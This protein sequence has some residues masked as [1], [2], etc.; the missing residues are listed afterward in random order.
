MPGSRLVTFF[1]L[2][3]QNQQLTVDSRFIYSLCSPLLQHLTANVDAARRVTRQVAQWVKP[4]PQ[5]D[6]CPGGGELMRMAFTWLPLRC[7]P[8]SSTRR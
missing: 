6:R 1:Y 3:E 7:S 8:L 2:F 4:K 5:K